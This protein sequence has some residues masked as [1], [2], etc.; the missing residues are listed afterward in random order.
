M[1]DDDG[2]GLTRP[3]SRLVVEPSSITTTGEAWGAV[4]VTTSPTLEA[5][6]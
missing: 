6:L 2:A 4:P 5:S 3:R 1:L